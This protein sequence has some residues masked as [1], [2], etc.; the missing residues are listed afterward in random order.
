MLLQRPELDITAKD[1]DGD[2]ALILAVQSE[3]AELVRLILERDGANVE[4]QDNDDGCARSIAEEFKGDTFDQREIL[5]LIK[6]HKTYNP[7][8][9]AEVRATGKELS[10]RRRKTTPE[11][12]VMPSSDAPAD[13]FPSI[14]NL[15]L[16]Q[17]ANKY[18]Y[19]HS[20]AFIRWM[21]AN[22]YDVLVQIA[23]KIMHGA[24]KLRMPTIEKF[25]SSE[26]ALYAEDRTSYDPKMLSICKQI[27]YDPSADYPLMSEREN[28]AKPPKPQPK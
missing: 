27:G 13:K 8:P 4:D 24:T 15:Q 12:F 5:R 22:N 18:S 25:L 11:D 9:V 16:R 14:K 19:P 6:E 7:T 2:T 20:V 23:G 10:A 26:D 28:S 3:N 1:E 21:E 17:I